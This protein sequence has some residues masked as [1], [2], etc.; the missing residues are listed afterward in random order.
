MSLGDALVQLS[1]TEQLCRECSVD[2]CGRAHAAKGLC[3]A[4]YNRVNQGKEVGGPFTTVKT[5]VCS[6]NGCDRASYGRGWCRVHWDRWRRKGDPLFMA[7]SRI[8]VFWSR[9]EVAEN[10][11]WLWTHSCQSEGYATFSE[12]HRHFAAHL[13]AYRTLVG[14]IPKGLTLDHLCH[15]RDESCA[16]GP[17]CLHRRCVNPSHLEAVTAVVNNLRGRSPMAKNKRKTHCMRGHEFTLENTR[18]SKKGSRQCRACQMAN[19]R[20]R[21]ALERGEAA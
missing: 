1:T 9:F 12:R 11:C 17:S 19:Q 18:I 15:T 20:E 7:A 16:G 8:E 4:H 2:G 21:R 13:Y 6:I 3:A 10:G 14:P 5:R